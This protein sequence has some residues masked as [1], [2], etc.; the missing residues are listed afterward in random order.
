MLSVR[1]ALG[2]DA[3]GVRCGEAVGWEPP[4]PVRAPAAA[5]PDREGG[6]RLS[7]EGLVREADAWIRRNRP[8]PTMC[9][10]DRYSSVGNPFVQ[11]A[12]AAFLEAFKDYR[13]RELARGAAFKLPRV[14]WGVYLLLDSGD[15]VLYVGMTSKPAARV[16]AHLREFGDRVARVH[17]EA[18]PNRVAAYD[19][20][21][22]L[23]AHF[24]PPFNVQ[25]VP[26]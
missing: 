14:G 18:H 24:R 7:A 22:E 10:P 19:R 13:R 21:T 17:W 8:D 1:I 16:A 5:S 26:T 12:E 11:E 20:E 4:T 23:I 15:R 25:K 3:V 2:T 6:E 9:D